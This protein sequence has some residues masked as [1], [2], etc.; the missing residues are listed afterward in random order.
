EELRLR[1]TIGLL[2]MPTAATGLAGIG[3]ADVDHTHTCPRRLVG[4]EGAE[5]GESPTVQHSP[6]ALA[7]RFSGAVTD[8]PQIFE[9]NPASGAFRRAEKGLRHTVVHILGEP[10]FFAATLL[11]EALGGLRSLLLRLLPE[12]AVTGAHLIHVAVFRTSRVIQ[13]LAIRSRR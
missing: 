9:S 4:N 10:F 8:G 13:K 11:Q 5:L 1:T 12:A 3:G 7:N 6:G 2:T